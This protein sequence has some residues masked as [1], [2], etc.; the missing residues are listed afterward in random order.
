MLTTSG[1]SGS[2]TGISSVEAYAFPTAGGSQIFLGTAT[3]GGARSDIGS[4]F[5]LSN[6]LST[7][8]LALFAITA[9]TRKRAL[10]WVASALAGVGA[11]FGFGGFAGAT[12]L[13]PSFY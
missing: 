1:R 4:L 12:W 13:L 11:M 10:F 8:G 6:A 9:L 5:D 2:G 7:I 3:Y